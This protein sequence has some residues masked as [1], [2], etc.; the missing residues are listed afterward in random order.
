MDKETKQKFGAIERD[1]RWTGIAIAIIS[2]VGQ[3]FT[4]NNESIKTLWSI[5][6]NVRKPGVAPP[7]DYLTF[8]NIFAASAPLVVVI[9]AMYVYVTGKLERGEGL[10]PW[11]FGVA[12]GLLYVAAYV[13]NEIGFRPVYPGGLG[14][15]PPAM[16][17]FMLQDYRNAY[18]SILFGSSIAVGVFMGRAWKILTSD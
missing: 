11:H 14:G 4:L 5:A 15:T 17:A 9:A 6:E 16:M 3:Q 8:W 10:A 1:A 13:G 7:G 2:L 18:G 12:A